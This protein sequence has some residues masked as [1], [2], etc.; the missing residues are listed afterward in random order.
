MP[1]GE[2]TDLCKLDAAAVEL[3]LIIKG[4]AAITLHVR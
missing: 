1:G 3:E 4:P 2:I